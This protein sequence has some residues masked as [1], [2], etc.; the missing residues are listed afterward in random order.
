MNYKIIDV[1]QHNG[2][3]NWSAIKSAGID[4]A[5]IRAGYIGKPDAQYIANIQ[6]AIKCGLHVGVYWFSYA[7]NLQGAIDDAAQCTAAIGEYKSKIDLGVWYDFEYDTER[8]AAEHGVKFTPKLRTD[9]IVQFC[10]RMISGGYTCGIYTNPNYTKNLLEYDRLK[11]YPL[12]VASWLGGT[13]YDNIASTA[14]P[15]AYNYAVLWQFT[16]AGKIPGANATNGNFDFNYFY[17][18][19]KEVEKE[20][21]AEEIKK[22]VNDTIDEREKKLTSAPESDWSAAAIK[23]AIDNKVFI[24]DGNGVFRWRDNI[25]REEIAQVLYNQ[26]K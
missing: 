6:G 25:T 16:S 9:I 21:T 20:L 19:L 22:I 2:V 13:S 12:W 14:K 3:L 18:D 8:Y 5:I 4:G 17:Y 15:Q 7:L 23:W 24:G 26:R 11:Q 10:D 1:S